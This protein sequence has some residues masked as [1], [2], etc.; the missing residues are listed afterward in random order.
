M[1]NPEINRRSSSFTENKEKNQK[2]FLSRQNSDSERKT[3]FSFKNH[4]NCMIKPDQMFEINSRKEKNSFFKKK[5]DE[6]LI[7]KNKT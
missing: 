6:L 5:E 1:I 4:V 7:D 2:E 3:S